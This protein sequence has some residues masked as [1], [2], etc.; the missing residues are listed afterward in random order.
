MAFPKSAA[1]ACVRYPCRGS[2]RL[3]RPG[4]VYDEIFTDPHCRGTR[5][6]ESGMFGVSL[7][8]IRIG[9][10]DVIKELSTAD[11]RT[12]RTAEPDATDVEC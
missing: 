3:F 4:S 11:H 5:F 8:S 7:A 10:A 12:D 6:H 2:S 9:V 1:T